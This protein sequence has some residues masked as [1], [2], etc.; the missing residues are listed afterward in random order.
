[1]PLEDTR[2][3]DIGGKT[4]DGGVE[5]VITDSGTTTDPV[6]RLGLLREKLRTYANY[7]HSQEFEQDF[8]GT[9]RDRGAI[10]VVCANPPTDEMAKIRAIAM[11]GD[12]P[13]TVPVIYDHF[14]D[15]SAAR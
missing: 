12:H 10:R 14:P 13:I 7:I 5:L 3:I 4:P 11:N 1:M 6:Q 2:A 9:A 15:T 8:P